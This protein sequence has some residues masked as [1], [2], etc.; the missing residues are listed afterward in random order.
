MARHAT[1]IGHLL[2]SRISQANSLLQHG[3]P[4]LAWDEGLHLAIGWSLE[5]YKRN[6]LNRLLFGETADQSS[7]QQT[8]ETV[9]LQDPTRLPQVEFT[10]S[11]IVSFWS[12]R[13]YP[14]PYYYPAVINESIEKLGVRSSR[15]ARNVTPRI[16]HQILCLLCLEASHRRK[17]EDDLSI[18]RNPR[19]LAQLGKWG[20]PKNAGWFRIF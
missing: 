2:A 1:T 11:N 16:G 3:A 15:N 4:C 19:G 7:F 5:S 8:Y 13:P 10:T 12:F 17:Q 18:C 14:S 20:S 6:N 9:Y